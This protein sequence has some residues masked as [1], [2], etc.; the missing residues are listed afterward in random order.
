M[1]EPKNSLSASRIKTLQS[2]SWL[3]YAKYVL[4]I[5]DASNDGANRG[6]ICH[7]IFE[8]LGNPRHKKIYNKIIKKQ[9]V[10]CYPAIERLIRKHA[11]ILKVDDEENIN[12]IKEMTLNGLMYDFFGLAAGKPSL[13]V[14]EQ[15]FDIVVNNGTFKYKIK[16]FIDKLFL[17]KNKKFALIRDFKTSKKKFEGK[18]V[19]DNLQDYMYSL[20]VRHLFPEYHNRKSEFL[21]LKF[22]LNAPKDSGVITMTEISDDD[23]EGFEHQLTAIQE[24]LDNFSEK[25]ARSNLAAKQPFPKDKSFS[26]PLQCGFAKTEGQLKIDGSVMWACPAKWSMHF[27]K[28]FDASG[29]FKKSYF[30]HE[31]N[32][33]LIPEGGSFER[34][35]YSGCPAFRQKKFLTLGENRLGCW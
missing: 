18:E 3:Y 27:Y 26:G 2:C 25:D 4:G 35:F 20:A 9:D 29:K 12:L 16:G 21:F 15:D 1:S 7:L 24:Y 30:E 17:Y 11:R 6:T 33:K 10:F 32:E 5:P 19:Y 8:V 14:S 34:V 13:A 22:D 28:T 31:W 23:L